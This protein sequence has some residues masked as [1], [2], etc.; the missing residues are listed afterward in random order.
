MNNWSDDGTVPLIEL[1]GVGAG[2]LAD[3]Q[4]AVET[5]VVVLTLRPQPEASWMSFNLAIT[6]AQAK[7]L[8]DDLT[9]LLQHSLPSA[10]AS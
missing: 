5:P 6:T 8:R 9:K 2:L 4:R 1:L 7:R 3:P 10:Q